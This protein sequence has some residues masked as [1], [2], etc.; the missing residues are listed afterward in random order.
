MAEPIFVNGITV[1][2]KEFDNGGIIVNL[3]IKI[4]DIIDFLLNQKADGEW[5][6]ID[7]KKGKESG[8]WYASLNTHK[9]ES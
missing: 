3:G 6:N 1:K 5:C 2:V 9:K 7:I 8:K 4:E